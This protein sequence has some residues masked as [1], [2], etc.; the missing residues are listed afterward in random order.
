MTDVARENEFIVEVDTGSHE[1]LPDLKSGEDEVED[2]DEGVGCARDDCYVGENVVEIDIVV[3]GF[4][5][6]RPELNFDGACVPWNQLQSVESGG[7]RVGN[8]DACATV[9]YA[10]GHSRV[11]GLRRDD[12]V[13]EVFIAVGSW[14]GWFEAGWRFFNVEFGEGLAPLA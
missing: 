11:V 14:S 8:G 1:F 12:G 6:A 3:A 4:D 2:T 10:L 9:E 5:V 7:V 13:L